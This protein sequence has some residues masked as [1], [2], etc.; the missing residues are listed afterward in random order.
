MLWMSKFLLAGALGT[1]A[2]VAPPTQSG[3]AAPSS[4]PSSEQLP[5]DLAELKARIGDESFARLVAHADAFDEH[6]VN[7]LKSW[8]KQGLKLKPNRMPK[9]LK[10]KLQ[11]FHDAYV[12]LAG[13]EG[14]EAAAGMKALSEFQMGGQAKGLDADLNKAK[15][16]LEA[17]KSALA[18]LKA[19][20]VDPGTRYPVRISYLSVVDGDKLETKRETLEDE[21]ALAAGTTRVDAAIPKLVDFAEKHIKV[22]NQLQRA[23]DTV[24][25]QLEAMVEALNPES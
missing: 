15:R 13:V 4:K 19:R 25:G 18:H 23:Q 5:A 11:A 17:L 16:G 6:L 22:R 14:A 1:T 3:V 10:K 7:V 24:G 21:K 2:F 12:K 9:L 20:A 8:D